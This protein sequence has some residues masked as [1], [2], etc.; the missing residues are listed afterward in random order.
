MLGSGVGTGVVVSSIK[1]ATNPIV[2][3]AMKVTTKS[4]LD[5]EDQI[6][7]ATLAIAV[8]FSVAALVLSDAKSREAAV[9]AEL[10]V[11]ES[12]RR[13]VSTCPT[14]AGR[15]RSWATFV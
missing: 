11:R 6:R 13:I 4:S 15:E 3:D 5:L 12:V 10:D 7:Q 9:A 8:N 2:S 14:C 1:F